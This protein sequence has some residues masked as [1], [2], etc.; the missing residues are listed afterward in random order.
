MFLGYLSNGFLKTNAIGM[1]I[2]T[3]FLELIRES[4]YC[5]KFNKKRI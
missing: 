2:F 4:D 1:H 5:L 3:H